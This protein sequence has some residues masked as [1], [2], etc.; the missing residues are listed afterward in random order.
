MKLFISPHN[1]DETLFS[2]FTIM[3]ER[4]SVLVVFDSVVQASRD[5]RAGP[6][7]RRQE[8]I[9]A[10]AE[11]RI[12]KEM[13]R[14]AGLNDAG[15]YDVAT[16]SRSILRTVQIGDD[17]E[18]FAPAFEDGG[19]DQHNVVARAA[20]SIVS[21][22]EMNLTQY[23]TYVRG[24]GKT[25]TAHPVTIADGDWIARKHRALACYRSQYM[26]AELG[27]RSWFEGDLAEY[28]L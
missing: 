12:P 15:N 23:T 9:D 16:V 25:R 7:E 26:N 11:L 6:V 2:A 28:Y 27:C 13:V 4:P 18:I 3:R 1:D 14:F 17:T 24:K 8:T 21:Q 20:E 10:L 5:P 19:H 22:T